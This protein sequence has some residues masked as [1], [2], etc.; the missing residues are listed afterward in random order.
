MSSSGFSKNGT[1]AAAQRFRCTQ[2]IPTCML[3]CRIQGRTAILAEH[4]NNTFVD[5]CCAPNKRAFA[6]TVTKLLVVFDDKKVL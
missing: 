3:N 6:I 5:V 1:T 4:R 2:F